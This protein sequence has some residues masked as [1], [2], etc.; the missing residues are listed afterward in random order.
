M[1]KNSAYMEWGKNK[2]QNKG[3]ILKEF[4]TENLPKIME[5]IEFQKDTNDR[6]MQDLYDEYSVAL[7]I[8]SMDI[9]LCEQ[10]I[11]DCIKSHETIMIILSA[12]TKKVTWDGN[13]NV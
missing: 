5:V 8:G 10:K 1:S 4:L 2:N 12:K 3:F 7:R 6:E 11:R 9:A 13:S